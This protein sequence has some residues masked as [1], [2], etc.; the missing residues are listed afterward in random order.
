MYPHV[1][2]SIILLFSFLLPYLS[3][4]LNQAYK[5]NVNYLEELRKLRAAVLS[6]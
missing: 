6:E 4:I 3:Y 1:S 5:K 2:L